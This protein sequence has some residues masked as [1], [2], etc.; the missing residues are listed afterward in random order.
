MSRF[1]SPQASICASGDLQPEEEMGNPRVVQE[2][3]AALLLSL[4]KSE[5]D[6]TLAL[7]TC[8][9][10]LRKH[11]IRRGGKNVWQDWAVLC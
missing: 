8:L 10:Y 3:L 1:Y 4:L 2:L 6:T 9:I 5:D 11:L 7:C